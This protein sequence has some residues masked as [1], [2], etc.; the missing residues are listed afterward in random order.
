MF[1]NCS[2]YGKKNAN[3]PCNNNANGTVCSPKCMTLSISLIILNKKNILDVIY[4]LDCNCKY[5]L[6]PFYG[7]LEN[8]TYALFVAIMTYK[9]TF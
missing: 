1:S 4:D 5:S 8:L 6:E 9:K 7:F 2:V 3:L